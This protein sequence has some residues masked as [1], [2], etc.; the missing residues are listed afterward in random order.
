M[1]VT[2][3]QLREKQLMRNAVSSEGFQLIVQKLNT[4][5]RALQNDYDSCVFATEAGIAKAMKI[6]A[7]REVILDHIPKLIEDIITVDA[8]RDEPKPWTFRAWLKS[9]KGA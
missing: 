4:A 1:V 3:S 6:Q 8:S 9:L 2:E 5:A 7:M